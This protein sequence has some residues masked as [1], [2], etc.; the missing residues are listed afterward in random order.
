MKLQIVNE[1]KPTKLTPTI[2]ERGG[3]RSATPLW[4]A[5]LGETA[6]PGPHRKRR[7]RLTLPA[8]FK[9]RATLAKVREGH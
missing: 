4:D 7:R 1:V 5:A 6:R 3:K 2:L 9:D 8:H